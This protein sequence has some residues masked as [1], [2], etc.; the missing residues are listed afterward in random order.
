[1]CMIAS[2]VTIDELVMHQCMAKVICVI[3][4]VLV[5]EYDLTYACTA[6]SQISSVGNY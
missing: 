4:R 1:M 3:E 5:E 2:P 6:V